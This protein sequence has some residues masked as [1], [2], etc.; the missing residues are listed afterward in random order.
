M[1]VGCCEN[2][3][4]LDLIE[5]LANGCPRCGGRMV[6][7]GIDSV[8]WNR[9][10]AEG[11][12][13]LI[14]RMLT[15]PILRPGNDPESESDIAIKAETRAVLLKQAETRDE[16]VRQAEAAVEHARQAE[17]VV[18]E[19]MK[20]ERDAALMEQ[21]TKRHYVFVCCKCNAISAHNRLSDRYYCSECGSLLDDSG[22]KTT[23][24]ATL[25]KEEKRQIL[26]ETQ[27]K[28]IINS[29]KKASFDDEDN[30]DDGSGI[31]NIV[32]VIRND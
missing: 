27:L 31:Q 20:A 3:R 29:I 2:C 1:Q 28:H 12:K 5:N 6:S 30:K 21:K 13:S 22:C 24:W 16:Q 32:N 15:E 11:K 14:I 19:A 23:D 18:E 4:Y 17:A 26:E 8:R 9:M 10:N 7:L 25:S